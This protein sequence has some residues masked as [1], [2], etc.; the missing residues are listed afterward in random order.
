VREKKQDHISEIERIT[1][2]IE[3][4]GA[5]LPRKEEVKKLK[6]RAK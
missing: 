6:K 2:E 1:K 5:L 4:K 3:E